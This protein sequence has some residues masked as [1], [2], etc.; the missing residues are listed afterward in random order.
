MTL[1]L[2]P[3]VAA[4]V[5]RAAATIDT[6]RAG[7]RSGTWIA[8]RVLER[9]I[10]DPAALR[11]ADGTAALTWPDPDAAAVLISRELLELLVADANR[12]RAGSE[13]YP[14]PDAG[15]PEL[16]DGQWW[17]MLLDLEPSNR[18]A[19]IEQLRSHARDGQTCW[20]HAHAERVTN[21]EA[22]VRALEAEV[23]TLRRTLAALRGPLAPLVDRTPTPP[24]ETPTRVLP[25]PND[26]DG[27]GFE[28]ETA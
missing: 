22:R 26:P 9:A 15:A 1:P 4:A 6:H 13:P 2:D 12:V 11:N 25:L 16:T 27:V 18:R 21:A 20:M 24:P 3:E 14:G 7:N 10:G 23:D 5:Q 28:V 19:A 17:A 8:Q